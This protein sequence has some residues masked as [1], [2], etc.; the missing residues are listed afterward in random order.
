MNEQTLL[1]ILG[2]L[3][4][5]FAFLKGRDHQKRKQLNER[6]E[7]LKEHARELDVVPEEE[8]EIRERLEEIEVEEAE[9]EE[10]E[11]VTDP[12]V[13]VERMRK[14]FRDRAGSA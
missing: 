1:I 2:A 11:E 10:P 6:L 7:D 12:H 14:W 5:L 13:A 9:I 3:G 4:A 8:T